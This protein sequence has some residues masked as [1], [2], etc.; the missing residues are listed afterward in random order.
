MAQLGDTIQLHKARYTLLAPLAS[1]SYGVVWRAW[2]QGR[3]VALK[4]INAAHMQ[5]VP[6]QQQQCWVASAEQEIRFLQQ[7]APWEQRHIA[8]LLD[9]GEHQNLPAFALELLGTDLQQHVQAMRQ[10]AQQ[11][12]LSQALAWLA[13]MNQALAKVHQYGYCYLDLKPAN[14]L[15]SHDQQH[16]KLVDFGSNKPHAERQQGYRGTPNWQAPEQFFPS[17]MDDAGWYYSSDYR[18]D[19]F[20]LGAMLYFLVCG[21]LPLRFCSLC[22]QAF[23]EHGV[24]GAHKISQ[25]LTLYPDEEALFLQ[26]VDGASGISTATAES[27]QPSPSA[28][29]S[30]ALLKTLLATEPQQRPQS[31]LDIAAAIAHV[32][33][34]G[35]VPVRAAQHPT[36]V[37]MP[38][39]SASAV[40]SEEASRWHDVLL[41]GVI[42]LLSLLVLALL[43]WPTS[44]AIAALATALT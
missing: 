15:L 32:Q 1:S 23:R 40:L 7:L 39:S 27:V 30:L 22:G 24:W 37:P 13:Q 17:D 5:Q 2:G 3:A 18:S 43:M 10:Q 4:L 33:Q 41:A 26:A 28:L 31:A 36:S 20:A 42:V 19:Y 6:Q 38:V 21:G 34:I 25:G 29:A 11:M 35:T 12:P 8:R 9:H 16:V 44:M 14:V